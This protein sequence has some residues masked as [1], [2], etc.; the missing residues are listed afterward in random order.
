MSNNPETAP[1]LEIDEIVRYVFSRPPGGKNTVSL[2]LT[3]ESRDDLKDDEQESV[4][5][6]IYIQIAVKGC[7]ILYG[8]DCKITNLNR[9]Q[10]SKIQ[11]YMNSMGV[12]LVVKCNDD[13]ADPWDLADAE[14]PTAIKYLRM[15]IEFI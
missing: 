1:D 12:K 10:F 8:E 3:P 13:L 5:L 6:E 15:S 2:Q 7:K 4:I 14:G 9:D 11:Q